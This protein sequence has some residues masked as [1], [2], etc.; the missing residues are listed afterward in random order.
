MQGA[1]CDLVREVCF[2]SPSIFIN[3]FQIT[4]KYAARVSLQLLDDAL[5]GKADMPSETIQA[6]EVVLRM[7]P[8]AVYVFFSIP[9]NCTMAVGEIGIFGKFPILIFKF[10][11]MSVTK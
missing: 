7:A 11:S 8:A 4:I 9:M 6:L 5:R 2:R 1:S 10:S 3:L